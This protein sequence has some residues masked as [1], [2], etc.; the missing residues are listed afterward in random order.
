MQDTRFMRTQTIL[1]ALKFSLAKGGF[2][3]D[4]KQ[5]KT[6]TALV[7]QMQSTK[8]VSGRHLQLTSLLKKGA[9]IKQMTKSTGASRRTVFRYLN[10]FEEAGIDLILEDGTYRFK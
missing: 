2:S 10:H 1:R 5:K 7:K 4:A 9:S 6:A 8:S 3:K